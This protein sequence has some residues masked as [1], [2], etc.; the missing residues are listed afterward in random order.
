VKQWLGRRLQRLHS[1]FLVVGSFEASLR[2]E[3]NGDIYWAGHLHLVI[4]GAGE[5]ELKAALMIE[6]RYRRRKYAKPVKVL[7]IGNLAERLGY[8]TKRIVKRSVAYVGKN[9]RQQRR[10]LPLTPKHQI[11]FD[12][13]LLGLP[14]GSRTILFG[15]R[16]HRR[17]LCETKR[18]V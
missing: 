7:P 2:V 18:A 10:E 8:S 15:C 5:D 12:S 6:R 17:R 13:W 14:V 3:L 9:G 11:E 16:L 1:P 4:A